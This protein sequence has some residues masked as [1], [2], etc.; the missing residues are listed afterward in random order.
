MKKKSNKKLLELRNL[1]NFYSERK[2]EEQ[3]NKIRE[4][5]IDLGGDEEIEELNKMNF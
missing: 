2:D 1:L 3:V 5:I 4:S